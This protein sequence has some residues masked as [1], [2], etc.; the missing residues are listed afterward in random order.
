MASILQSPAKKI[1]KSLE[2]FT[3]N[4]SKFENKNSWWVRYLILMRFLDD[5]FGKPYARS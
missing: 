5:S 4:D 3:E 1:T 2:N